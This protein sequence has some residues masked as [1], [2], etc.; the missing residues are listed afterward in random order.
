MTIRLLTLPI[1]AFFTLASVAC[2]QGNDEPV[3]TDRDADGIEDAEDPDDDNDG[4]DDDEDNDDDNKTQN[5]Q[6]K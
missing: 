6:Q 3:Y 2:D 5:K 1:V 4:I